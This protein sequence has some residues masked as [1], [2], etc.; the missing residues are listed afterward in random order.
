VVVHEFGHGVG[1]LAVR[2]VTDS[3][4]HD[5]AVDAFEPTIEFL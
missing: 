1:C 5:S 4:E 3:F 2:K